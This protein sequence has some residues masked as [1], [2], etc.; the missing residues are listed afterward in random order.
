VSLG[1]GGGG[2][3]GKVYGLQYLYLKLE[4][5]LELD[6]GVQAATAG[7]QLREQAGEPGGRGGMAQQLPGTACYLQTIQFLMSTSFLVSFLVTVPPGK[8]LVLLPR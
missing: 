6:N 3:A 7:R 5:Y 2:E 8:M 1:G 4:I